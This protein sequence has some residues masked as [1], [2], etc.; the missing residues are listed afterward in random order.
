MLPLLLSYLAH[1][2]LEFCLKVLGFESQLYRRPDELVYSRLVA[3]SG[4]D[5]EKV[6]VLV[7][8]W[9]SF[10]V[11]EVESELKALVYNGRLGL[12]GLGHVIIVCPKPFYDQIMTI[13]PP[14]RTS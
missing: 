11:G 13:Y 2:S 4:S 14:A 3:L 10:V 5:G 1:A 6:H 7:H 12:V 9:T 8:D